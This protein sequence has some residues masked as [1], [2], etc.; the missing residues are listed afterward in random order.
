MADA[1]QCNCEAYARRTPVRRK[2]G[3]TARCPGAAIQ[4]C[5][6]GALAPL[7]PGSAALAGRPAF[8]A[9]LGIL[10]NVTWFPNTP[11]RSPTFR[12]LSE[13]SRQGA[14]A[15]HA[16]GQLNP[17]VD[18]A[19][20]AGEYNARA[21]AADPRAVGDLV[22]EERLWVEALDRA[23]D[24]APALRNQTCESESSSGTSSSGESPPGASSG[25][26][27]G[28]RVTVAW[29]HP[30]KLPDGAAYDVRSMYGHQHVGGRSVRFVNVTD[31]SSPI[32]ICDSI[33]R[34]GNKEGIVGDEAG[35]IVDIP[36]CRFDPPLRLRGG[37]TYAI[38]SEYGADPRS[39]APAGFL[40]LEGVMG[41]VILRFT[42]PDEAAAAVF[43]ASGERTVASDARRALA[44]GGAGLCVAAA[45]E[46]R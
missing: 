12:S 46:R 30:F 14:D 34:Y 40:G 9:P 21:C 35:F 27:A 13:P 19:A 1:V 16:H 29:S 4:C 22:A 43:S 20:C 33:P 45:S 18:G 7:A 39:H 23:G 32:T 31:P 44:S 2:T 10:Y 38:R 5:G 24:V 41:Y 25:D 42:I 8:A 11:R 3:I 15:N 28:P 17:A 6:D 37:E 26:G 36:G